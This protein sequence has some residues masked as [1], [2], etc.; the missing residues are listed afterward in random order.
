MMDHAIKEGRG[1]SLKS[2][3]PLNRFAQPKEIARIVLFLASEGTEN[4]T[5]CIIDSNGASYLRT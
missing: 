2:Q 4:M 1:E 5:G 3:S